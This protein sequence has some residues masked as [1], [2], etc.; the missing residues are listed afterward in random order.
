MNKFLSLL[1]FLFLL[2]TATF[3]QTILSFKAMG[4]EDDA[5]QGMVGSSAYYIKVDPLWE[6]N[7]SQLVLYFQPS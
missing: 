1:A 3:A 5:I 2:N 4:H 6:L 7:G